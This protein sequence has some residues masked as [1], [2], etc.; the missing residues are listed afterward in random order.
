MVKA[1]PFWWNIII[2]LG[3]PNLFTVLFIII[4]FIVVFDVFICAA[5][6][7][8]LS[9]VGSGSLSGWVTLLLFLILIVVL[10][11]L[12]RIIVNVAKGSPFIYAL[13]AIPKKIP[14]L[15]SDI[16]IEVFNCLLRRS[17][18]FT[19]RLHHG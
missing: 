16:L 11:A 13:N 2:D 10:M 12:C 4:V 17:K 19:H 3:Q 5:K 1:C 18:A 9:I 6:I 7:S 14:L 15:L 8:R